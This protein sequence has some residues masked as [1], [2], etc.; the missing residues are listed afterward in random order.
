[1]LRASEAAAVADLI[2]IGP[3]RQ[4]GL[5][6]LSEGLR[7]PWSPV[8]GRCLGPARFAPPQGPPGPKGQNPIACYVG[9]KGAGCAKTLNSLGKVQRP[10]RS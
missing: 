9:G 6:T 5:I 4:R 8:G 2:G 1:M 3:K 10:P 7:A